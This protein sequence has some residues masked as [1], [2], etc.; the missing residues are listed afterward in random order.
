MFLLS[1]QRLSASICGYMVL[2]LRI[3]AR[4]LICGRFYL[5]SSAFPP[6]AGKLGGE[7]DSFRC[8][9]TGPRP[10]AAGNCGCMKTLANFGGPGNIL[11]RGRLA[12]LVERLLHTQEA[13]GS[14]PVAPTISAADAPPAPPG[15]N[16]RPASLVNYLY[17]AEHRWPPKNPDSLNWMKQ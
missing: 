2:G 16:V 10:P 17:R 12:Q 5:A 13:T 15:Y 7:R 9:A 6:Q 1:Y 14:S 3:G 11:V 4:F 8:A